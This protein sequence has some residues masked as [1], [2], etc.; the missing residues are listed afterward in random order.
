MSASLT[1]EGLRDFM[2]QLGEVPTKVETR[3]QQVIDHYAQQL[4][5]SVRSEL[6]VLTGELAGTVAV[7]NE[8]RMLTRVVYGGQQ[9]QP[10]EYA[11]AF[12]KGSPPRTTQDGANRGRMP[13]KWAM[14]KHAYRSRRQMLR[15]LTGILTEEL[16]KL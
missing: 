5:Q 13:A 8:G 14:R 10:G 11:L 6:P 7:R 2:R 15:E 16:R 9:G 4:A 12:E 3:G 1:L